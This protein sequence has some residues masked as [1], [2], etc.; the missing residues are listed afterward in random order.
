V[1]VAAL[2]VG[3]WLGGRQIYFLGID[4]TGQV[5]LY[6]GLPYV[7]PFDVELY[8]EV[9]SEGV[10]A[11]RLPADR[12]DEATNHELRSHDDA[13][14]LLDDLSAAAVTPLPQPPGAAGGSSENGSA[15]GASQ[16][17]QNVSA[18]GSGGGGHR[19]GGDGHGS[20]S[21]D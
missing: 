19:K 14:D 13:L 4:D 5:A 16:T 7:L 3:A 12:R 2:G 1:V 15:G 20:G 9:E 8:S 18:G 21:G 10:P 11:D 6:R 17:S